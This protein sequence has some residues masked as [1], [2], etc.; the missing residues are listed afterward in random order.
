MCRHVVLGFSGCGHYVISY[1]CEVSLAP[2]TTFYRYSL[3]WWNFD[4]YKK[5]RQV[6]ALTTFTTHY[7]PPLYTQVASCD[8][9]RDEAIDC[10]LHLIVCQSIDQRHVIVLG[11]RYVQ[12]IHVFKCRYNII[13]MYCTHTLFFCVGGLVIR[14]MNSERV[15]WVSCYAHSSHLGPHPL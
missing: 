10:E 3:H 14:M 1:C 6:W 2:P 7:H 5:L 11:C 13:C 8:L 9:F 4:L 15:M 12:C